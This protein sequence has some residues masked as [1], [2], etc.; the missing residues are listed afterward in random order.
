MK[1]RQPFQ[2]C[3]FQFISSELLMATR[4]PGV[5]KLRLVVEISHYLLGGGFRYL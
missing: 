1:S 4:S 3:V 5:Q 2:V